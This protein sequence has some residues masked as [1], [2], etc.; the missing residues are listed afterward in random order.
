MKTDTRSG[1][2]SGWGGSTPGG[3][4]LRENPW[5]PVGTFGRIVAAAL[6]YFVAARLAQ[7]PQFTRVSC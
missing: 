1:T 2:R 5:I 3:S 6:V 4:A 7:L